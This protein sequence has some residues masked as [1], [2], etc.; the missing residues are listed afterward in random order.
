MNAYLVCYPRSGSHWLWYCI[1]HLTTARVLDL[2]ASRDASRQTPL[3]AHT[4]GQS[5]EWWD[6][7]NRERDIL[8]F[9]LRNPKECVLRHL[10][11]D[12][13]L[14]HP[15]PLPLVLSE[16]QGAEQ[17]VDYM[18]L[19]ALYQS[20][21]LEHRHL[22]YYEDLIRQPVIVLE[23]LL[24]FLFRHAYQE[25]PSDDLPSFSEHLGQHRDA[26][27]SLYERTVAPSFTLGESVHYHAD[28]LSPEDRR[29]VDRHLREM[30]PDLFRA[31]LTR[32]EEMPCEDP[33]EM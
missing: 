30:F 20:W 16:M 4:H 12:S 25:S 31:Y 13:K 23:A 18:T 10:R 7:I 3:I 11:G 14:P 5:P 33:S 6:A 19:L 2:P 17:Q 27:L 9:L 26:S 24:Q 32:Y 21:S 28:L 29:A 22:V 1:E 15:P 8:I